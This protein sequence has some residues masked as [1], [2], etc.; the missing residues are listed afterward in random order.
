MKRRHG[1]FAGPVPLSRRSPVPLLRGRTKAGPCASDRLPSGTKR[2]KAA[3]PDPER[4]A[5]LRV[6]HRPTTTCSVFREPQ[7]Q[8]AKPFF[9]PA[10]TRLVA[11]KLPSEGGR[12]KFI[13][14]QA[15]PDGP[16]R[17]DADRPRLGCWPS[18]VRDGAPR[19]DSALSLLSRQLVSPWLLGR[20]GLTRV[21]RRETTR[22]F[23]FRF[24]CQRALASYC[25]LLTA[26]RSQLTSKKTLKL[27][28]RFYP[29]LPDFTRFDAGFHAA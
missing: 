1:N 21:P 22:L 8:S 11:P 23:L 15:V 6:A 29:T 3:H 26:C 9:H 5:L 14:S 7:P 27:I 12:K 2:H 16:R 19:S 20:G 17:T 4:G 25:S 28:T 24:K 18:R 13:R 10:F